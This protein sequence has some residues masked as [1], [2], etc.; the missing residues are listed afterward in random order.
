MVKQRLLKNFFWRAGIF[1]SVIIDISRRQC[2]FFIYF[3]E[4]LSWHFWAAEAC[5]QELILFYAGYKYFWTL[6]AVGHR[7]HPG[8]GE[9]FSEH[10]LLSRERNH[11]RIRSRCES[12]VNIPFCR[13]K[14]WTVSIKC[15][16]FV[17]K[18]AM[19]TA[20]FAF[21][22]YETMLPTYSPVDF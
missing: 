20:A 4:L 10:G 9:A 5:R 3:S 11:S 18:M 16:N 17:Q 7:E 1:S 8:G 21:S 19:T 15:F 13:W 12:R 14:L 22:V 6:A 2:S